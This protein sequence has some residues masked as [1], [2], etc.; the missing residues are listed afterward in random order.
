MEECQIVLKEHDLLVESD[1]WCITLDHAPVPRY[2]L[3][4]D[5]LTEDIL[6]V[7]ETIYNEAIQGLSELPWLTAHFIAD[8][9]E[10][11]MDNLQVEITLKNDHR[12]GLTVCRNIQIMLIGSKGFFS[13]PMSMPGCVGDLRLRFGEVI[14]EGKDHNL[15]MYG[16]DLDQW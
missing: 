1:G 15:S 2:F 3:A 13:I 6:G 8:F 11:P 10:L 7:R 12:A 14:K 16:R 5:L 4:E 9:Q